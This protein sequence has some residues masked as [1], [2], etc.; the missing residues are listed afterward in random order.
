MTAHYEPDPL[1][2]EW[3]KLAHTVTE[4]RAE[5]RQLRERCAAYAAAIEAEREA[6]ARLCDGYA[7]YGDP[8]TNWAIDCAIAIRYR[9]QSVTRDP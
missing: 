2:A 8:M 3:D 4:Y 5:I 7:E 9:S 1:D 6:C